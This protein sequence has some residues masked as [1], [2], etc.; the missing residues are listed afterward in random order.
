[1]SSDEE[2]DISP[3]LS[4]SIFVG[5]L[6]TQEGSDFDG[7][8]GFKIKLVPQT[9]DLITAKQ[10][11][12]VKMFMSTKDT[13]KPIYLCEKLSDT[14][15]SRNYLSPLKENACEYDDTLGNRQNPSLEK[16]R[17][18]NSNVDYPKPIKKK[19]SPKKSKKSRKESISDSEFKAFYNAFEQ[20]SYTM[21]KKISGSHV[22]TEGWS[23]KVLTDSSSPSKRKVKDEKRRFSINKSSFG[24]ISNLGKDTKTQ[25]RYSELMSHTTK[26]I[27]Q[28]NFN[29][30]SIVD[31]LKELENEISDYSD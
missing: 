12:E 24:N 23:S 20:Q 29:L 8:S 5:N 2:R 1:M 19:F 13:L 14:E 9:I 6:D 18:F 7:D 15:V 26:G 25:R 22:S 28:L 27:P 30:E 17:R 4:K 10:E 11:A 3:P 16:R 31:T 21:S